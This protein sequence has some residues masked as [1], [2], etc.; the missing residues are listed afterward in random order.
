VKAVNKFN[1]YLKFLKLK[2]VSL[3]SI[4]KN[5]NEFLSLR[6]SLIEETKKKVFT[7][8]NADFLSF[9]IFSN[10]NFFQKKHDKVILFTSFFKSTPQRNEEHFFSINQN[11]NNNYIDEVIIFTDKNSSII[12]PNKIRD[13]LKL[14]IVYHESDITFLDFFS[15]FKQGYSSKDIFIVA[16]CDCYFDESIKILLYLDFSGKKI[17]CCTRKE[18]NKEGI[19]SYAESIDSYNIYSQE[20]NNLDLSSSDCFILPFDF[21]EDEILSKSYIGDINIEFNFLS[22]CFIKKYIIQNI[23]CFL[24]CIHHHESQFRTNHRNTFN[25]FINLIY[26]NK[27]LNPVSEKN[28][29]FGTWRLR[30]KY[31]YIDKNSELQDFGDYLPLNSSELMSL[32]KNIHTNLINQQ[33]LC[34]FYILTGQEIKSN[35]FFRSISSFFNLLPSLKYKVKIFCFVN[36]NLTD[37]DSLKLKIL[38]S[39]KYKSHVIDIEFQH[40]DID[41]IDD[42][43]IR[44]FNEYKKLE[45]KPTL[46]QSSGPNLMFYKSITFLKNTEYKNFLLLESDCTCLKS[47]WLD[48]LLKFISSN[49]FTISGGKYTGLNKYNYEQYFSG[50]ING[51]AIYS[52]SALLHQYISE[53]ISLIKDSLNKSEIQ[54]LRE[55]YKL[56]EAMFSFDVALFLVHKI[57]KNLE[58]YLENNFFS[59]L[60]DSSDAFIT[61]TEVLIKNKDCIILHQKPIN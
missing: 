61:K 13:N 47:Y 15:Y 26:P 56:K 46:G 10:F 3:A 39:L 9:C 27:S 21:K 53:S 25:N 44:D 43:Y 57:N 1:Y 60:T 6:K 31:N 51:S 11:L 45:K 30:N 49:H 54:C 18:F 23:F 24:N 50:H 38:N 35:T 16:N 2:M 22:K 58:S 41:A 34:L 33:T 36:S 12:L 29:I 42:I 55:K 52:N 7:I 19:L 14:K 59:I 5:H 37:T 8:I 40:L 4:S 20:K 32:D 48:N 17:F 28:Y